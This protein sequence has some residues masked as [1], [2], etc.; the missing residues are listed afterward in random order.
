[1]VPIESNLCQ[2]T[3]MNLFIYYNDRFHY[4]KIDKFKRKYGGNIFVGKLPWILPTE[5]FHRYLPREL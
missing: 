3:L 4:Q 5:I 1:M 2:Q